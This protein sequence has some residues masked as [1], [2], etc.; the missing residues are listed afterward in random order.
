MIGYIVRIETGYNVVV[1]YPFPLQISTLE[2][3][4]R[5]NRFN[6]MGSPIEQGNLMMKYV[7]VDSQTVNYE[8]C[9]PFDGLLDE[10]FD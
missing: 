4:A 10:S 7:P 2:A 8:G 5:R 3:A 6:K 9:S 1:I